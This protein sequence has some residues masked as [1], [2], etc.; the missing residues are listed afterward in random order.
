MA[1]T[2]HRQPFMAGM[3]IRKGA[4]LAASPA[5]LSPQDEVNRTLTLASRAKC[6]QQNFSLDSPID[7]TNP[8]GCAKGAQEP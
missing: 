5:L 7:K 1:S 8:E 4:T 3:G 6:P 2:H